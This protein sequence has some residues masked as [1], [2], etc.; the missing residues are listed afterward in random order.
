MTEHIRQHLYNSLGYGGEMKPVPDLD[1][2]RQTEWSPE[3]ERYMRNRLVLG[4]PFRYGRLGTPGKPQWDRMARISQE[5]AEYE[6]TG[7]LECLVDIANHVL[8]EFVEGNHPN[9]HFGARDD[10]AHTERV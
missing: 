7:N 6:R 2:L 9:K 3:F 1:V 4:G 10:S 5:V 8:L